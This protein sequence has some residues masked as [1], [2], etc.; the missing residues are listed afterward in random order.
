ML[1]DLTPEQALT[2]LKFMCAFAWSDLRV[3]DIERKVISKLALRLGLSPA[4]VGQVEHWLEFPPSEDELDPYE[5]PREHR[6][7]FLASALEIT[8]ADGFDRLEA[9]SLAIF[10]LLTREDDDA[11]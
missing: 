11:T 8:C 5:I 2:F 1:R 4:Q 10:D 7:L 6:R 9:E 3:S